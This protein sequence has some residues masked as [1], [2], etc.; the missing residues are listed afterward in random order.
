MSRWTSLAAALLGAALTACAGGSS[1]TAPAVPPDTTAVGPG[2]ASGVSGARDVTFQLSGSASAVTYRCTL[3]GAP[4]ACSGPSVTVT[5]LAPGLHVFT[6][7][8]VDANG[9]A[10]PT[11]A[12]WTWT[13][14]PALPPPPTFSVTASAD[15]IV[16]SHTAP[17]DGGA[18][19]YF[20][21]S[22]ATATAH[23]VYSTGSPM[24]L[25]VG[26]PGPDGQLAPI[27]PCQEYWVTGAAFDAASHL[28]DRAGERKSVV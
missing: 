8:A 16:V 3:D 28:S 14:D 23:M 12:V 7:V 25:T 20:G 21:H 19:I 5:G 6:A 26:F 27:A 1:P 17:A 10:D 4:V 11:P 13:M 22:A 9:L 24:T 2:G 18:V 15:Q